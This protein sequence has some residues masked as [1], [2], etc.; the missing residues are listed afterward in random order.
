M[1]RREKKTITFLN[2]DINAKDLMNCISYNERQYFHKPIWFRVAPHNDLE[3]SQS[4][5]IGMKYA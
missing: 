3:S 1:L 4:A 5:Q 2:L